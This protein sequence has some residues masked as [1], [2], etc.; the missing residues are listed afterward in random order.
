[1][2]PFSDAVNHTSLYEPPRQGYNTLGAGNTPRTH[3][4]LG[5]PPPRPKPLNHPFIHARQFHI[6]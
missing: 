2:I 3:F 5:S 1:M 4:D 6:L